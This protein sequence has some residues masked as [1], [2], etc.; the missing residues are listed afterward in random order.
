MLG[1]TKTRLIKRRK[2][3]SSSLKQKKLLHMRYRGEFYAIPK[4]IAEKYK[5][6][7]DSKVSEE[8]ILANDFFADL[9]KKFT[10]AGV[11]LQGTRYRENMIQKDFAEKIGVTQADLSKMEKGTRPIGKTVAKRI[12]KLFGVD[13]RYF[14]Q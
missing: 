4:K 7:S 10:R 13:Y 8:S 1:P 6:V 14:L 9:D 11:L 5:V 12:A 3:V 2:Q